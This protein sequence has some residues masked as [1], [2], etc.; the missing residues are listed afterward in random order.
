MLIR[1]GTDIRSSEVTDR[2]LWLDRRRFLALGAAGALALSGVPA[3]AASLSTVRGKFAADEPL[4]PMKDV[5][6]YTNFY[7]LGTD[8]SDPAQLAPS[9]FTKVKPWSV[10]VEGECA[11]PATL[12]YEDL[13]K[14]HQLEERIYRMRCVEAWSMVIP[15]VGVPLGDILRRFEPSSKAKYVV[16]TTL[17]DPE[18]LPGQRR[19]ILDWPYVE[20]LRMD[21]AMHP[22][23]LL[24]V[25]LYGEELLP[26]NGAPIRLVVPWKYGFK[27]IK[28][29]VG[30]RFTETPPRTAWMKA[31]A[32]EYGFYANVNPAVDHPRWSQASERRIGEFLKRKT[33]PFNG[34]AEQVASLYSGMDLAVNY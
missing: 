14:P 10:A 16:F 20:A 23:T 17:Q 24:A 7:E 28:S 15:W 12:G 5:T 22:L 3:H 4:T 2:S 25:G 32:R 29:I 6:T 31:A 27:G 21:E 1:T 33:L 9:Y 13:I 26:Q 18:R 19:A 11:K 30:I 8:K 34:Y